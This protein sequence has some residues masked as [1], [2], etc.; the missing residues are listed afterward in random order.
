MR[1]RQFIAD[2]ENI[3]MGSK[4]LGARFNKSLVI[5]GIKITFLCPQIKAKIFLLDIS[6]WCAKLE[7][8]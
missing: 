8:C 5:Y 6:F 4:S 2:K 1:T 7:M 3:F